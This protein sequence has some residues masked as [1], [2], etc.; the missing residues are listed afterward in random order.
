MSLF[1]NKYRIESIRL[2]GYDY[3][4]TGIYFVTICCYQKQHFF[5]EINNGHIALSPI[6]R[7]A[8]QYW[9]EIPKHY[10]NIKLDEYIIMP[11]HIHGLINII[12]NNRCANVEAQ[13]FVPLRNV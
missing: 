6:G 8:K 2:A 7:M 4:Q 1:K 3:S 9:L 13:N 5:G 12:N 10:P 11:D